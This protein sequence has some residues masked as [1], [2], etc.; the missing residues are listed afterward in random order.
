MSPTSQASTPTH[1]PSLSTTFARG[2]TYGDKGGW[3]LGSSLVFTVPN[4]ISLTRLVTAPGVAYLV[5]CG[6]PHI[7]LAALATSAFSDVLDGA[8]AKAYPS[9]KSTLGSYLDPLADK[10][11]VIA[12]GA[13]LAASGTGFAAV[14][15]AFASF[16]ARDVAMVAGGFYVRASTLNWKWSGATEFF[17]L[18][19]PPRVA[20]GKFSPAADA[21]EPLAVAKA[22]TALQLVAYAAALATRADPDVVG[23]LAT[24]MADD[25]LGVLVATAS[26]TTL[27]STA[28]YAMRFSRVF[29]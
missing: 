13:A 7:A 1:S 29:L 17:R 2:A 21:V 25:S 18:S 24:C 20:L 28:G 26:M 14:D 12:T 23:T 16:A 5:A 10:A 15:A 8:V 11:L 22:N 19:E 6:T 27:A 9:Q 3:S 4:A